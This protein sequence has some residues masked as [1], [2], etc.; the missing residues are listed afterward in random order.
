[1]WTEGLINSRPDRRGKTA[2][3]LRQRYNLRGCKGKERLIWYAP[4]V[5]CKISLLFIWWENVLVHAFLVLSLPLFF[6]LCQFR[7]PF[8]L[9]PH[10]HS[11]PFYPFLSLSLIPEAFKAE[12]TACSE[13]KTEQTVSETEA[14]YF[15][16]CLSHFLSFPFPLLTQGLSYLFISPLLLRGSSAVLRC[17]ISSM[18]GGSLL[19]L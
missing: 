8:F 11:S 16:S 3:C 6:F 7:K 4:C 19:R 9:S 1:M 5:L 10:L 12:Q 13:N 14:Q 18:E 2:F 17:N 15:T